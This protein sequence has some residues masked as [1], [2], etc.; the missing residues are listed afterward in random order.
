MS[1]TA[2]THRL[3]AGA[4][5]L[6]EA[7][8]SG[9]VGTVR[10]REPLAGHTSLRVGGP[11]AALV[12]AESPRDLAWVADVCSSQ[13]RPW[14][15]LGRGSNLLVAD[16]GWMGAVVTLGRGF[17]GLAEPSP[18]GRPGA[19]GA[20]LVVA[21]AAEPMPA[22]AAKAAQLGLAGLAFGVAIPGTLGGAVKMNAGAHNGQ[23]SDVLAWAEGVRLGDEARVQRWSPEELE[24]GYRETALPR[25]A[26]VTRAGLWLRPADG[27]TLATDMAEMR[28]WRRDHQPLNEPSCGSVFRNPQGESAGRLVE[29]AGMKGHRVGRARVSEL[30]ANFITTEPGAT[31]AQVWQVI[32]DTRRAVAARHGVELQTEVVVAG[33]ATEHSEKESRV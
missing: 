7:L 4:D 11:A 30:H 8:A 15:I 12:R 31:A 26:V 3:A 13:R 23:L 33:F 1:D 24:M 22:A 2:D 16:E 27:E 9:V 18:D 10:A 25:D 14:L 21:G 6:V 20:A 28:Q 5:E 29:T 32:A 19:G 17:R